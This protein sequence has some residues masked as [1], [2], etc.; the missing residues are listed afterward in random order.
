MHT[1]TGGCP[2]HP[3]TSLPSVTLEGKS[4]SPALA[5]SMNRSSACF[6]YR[7]AGETAC[8]C[9]RLAGVSVRVPAPV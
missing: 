3:C 4:L 6:S 9:K 8:P 7:E 2:L 1:Y 5:M